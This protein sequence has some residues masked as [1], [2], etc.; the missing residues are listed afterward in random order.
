MFASLPWIP[1]VKYAD[2]VP[3]SRRADV[4]YFICCP[5][6]TKEIRDLY[7][8]YARRFSKFVPS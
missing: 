6:A 5:R 2:V 7:A 8:G 4:F 3:T 1:W